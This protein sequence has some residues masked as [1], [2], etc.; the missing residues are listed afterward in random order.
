MGLGFFFS[1]VVWGKGFFCVAVFWFGFLVL[2]GWLVLVA[3]FMLSSGLGW[4][5]QN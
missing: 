5:A 2:F 3:L 4:F 1:L